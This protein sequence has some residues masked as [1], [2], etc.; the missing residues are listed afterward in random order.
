MKKIVHIGVVSGLLL[1]SG[2]NI[3]ENKENTENNN[4]TNNDTASNISSIRDTKYPS[5]KIVKA[6][7]VSITP[8]ITLSGTITTKEEITIASE[9]TGTVKKVV[10]KEG[11]NISEGQVI[12]SL[13]SQSNLLKASYSS[14]IVALQNAR[15]GFSL[16]KKSAQQSLKDADLQ[17]KNANLALNNAEIA[18]NR[19]KDSE[20]FK[21][22]SN[23]A[24]K[25][26]SDKIL[27]IAKK[28]LEISK[29]SLADILEMAEQTNIRYVDTI[30]SS[31]ASSLIAMRGYADFVDSLIGASEFK[32][33]D[34]DSFE[35]Y[36][37]GTSGNLIQEIQTEWKIFS[38]DLHLLEVH[39]A[40]ISKSEYTI[41]DKE[42]LLPILSNTLDRAKQ[43][44]EILRKM[45]TMLNK[46]VS[47]IS[48]PES[49]ISELKTKILNSQSLLE[50]DMQSLKDLRQSISDFTIQ[51]SQ[52]IS[53]AE[54][55]IA[56]R[57]SEVLAQESQNTVA[58]SS[59][60]ITEVSINSE[61]V[62]AKNAFLNAE[63]ALEFAKSQKV[64]VS[65]QGDLTI[66]SALAQMDASQS[67]LDQA[68][69]SLSKLT[70]TSGIKGTVSKVLAFAGDTVSPGTPLMIISDYSELKL[71][72]DVSLEESFLIKKGMKAEVS[73][74]GIKKTFIGT[75]SIIYPEAD[76]ITR[77]VRIEILIPNKEKIPAN[78]F[79]TAKLKLKK[80]KPQIYIPSKLLVSQNPPS[81][82]VLTRKKCT[83]EEKETN[84]C[85]VQY[86]NKQL[87]ILEKKEL[88]LNNTEETEFGLPVKSGLRRNQYILQDKSNILFEGDIVLLQENKENNDTNKNTEK[89]E[90]DK[91]TETKEEITRI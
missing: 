85:I 30:A 91:N 58:K 16:A 18:Y 68:A 78:V 59:E 31:T 10:K 74:D 25:E 72:S 3:L 66:Q 44:Q 26:N 84:N 73:I 8:E 12:M 9:V 61:L 54:L 7:P 11:D 63:N 14:A 55:A 64:S 27:E 79:A 1:F 90:K 41:S 32:K 50:K 70:I 47:S 36:L 33:H 60:G 80:E 45:E 40:K 29:K 75:V 22:N 89:S 19:L 48:F 37:S 2:C 57:E 87:Y 13:E 67:L 6:K 21:K 15:K 35:V 65:I 52:K 28:N 17:I 20:V 76:K 69:L 53:A 4:D 83:K 43:M 71:V 46:S 23:T 42:I 86:N 77:R 34:N 5:V 56:L 88:I 39:F 62:A 24:T 81:V 51:N 38:N 49:R 82:M